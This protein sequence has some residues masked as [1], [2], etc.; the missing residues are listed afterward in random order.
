MKAIKRNW[1]KARWFLCRQQ[2]SF[3]LT[4]FLVSRLATL[5]DVCVVGTVYC[6][7]WD[8]HCLP[9]PSEFIYWSRLFT[10][11]SKFWKL[12]KGSGLLECHDLSSRL[13]SWQGVTCEKILA[14]VVKLEKESFWKVCR[15]NILTNRTVVWVPCCFVRRNSRSR[16]T[17][18]FRH[19]ASCILGQAFRCSP[20]N[21]FYIFNQ[22]IYF[23]IWYLLDRAII[24]I[25]NMDNQLDATITAY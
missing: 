8:S 24:D 22:Q 18:T 10:R 14:G 19:R 16:Y 5:N 4:R 7:T 17:L 21:D 25:N 9:L 2:V 11:L 20:E 1:G 3:L 13:V 15:H 23:I 6:K 12:V